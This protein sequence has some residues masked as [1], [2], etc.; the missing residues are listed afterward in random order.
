MGKN[1]AVILAGG[2]GSRSGLGSP[3]QFFKVAGKTVIEHTVNVFDNHRLIDEIAIV[4]HPLYNREIEEMVIR[5]KWKKVKKILAGGK[6]RYESSLA[7][8]DA[9]SSDPECCLI[10]HDA[11]RPLISN[12]I[13]DGIVKALE[14]YNAVDVAVPA[15]D[16]IIQ[17]DAKGEV[18]EKIPDRRFLRRVDHEFPI[19]ESTFLEY[20]REVLEHSVGDTSLLFIA[21]VIQ[22]TPTFLSIGNIQIVPYYVDI[23]EVLNEQTMKTISLKDGDTFRY[24]TT[25]SVFKLP[26]N[27]DFLT[28]SNYSHMALPELALDIEWNASP[29]L[30]SQSASIMKTVT[31][32]DEFYEQ[33]E[34][35]GYYEGENQTRQPHG[36]YCN[37]P[38]D[39]T[40]SSFTLQRFC[41]S[42][43]GPDI[44]VHWNSPASWSDV[45]TRSFRTHLGFLILVDGIEVS[46]YDVAAFINRISHWP[47]ETNRADDFSDL[48]FTL[49][50]LGLKYKELQ[51][52]H[53][54]SIVPYYVYYTRV[55]R[56][57]PVYLS[58]EPVIDA[59]WLDYSSEIIEKLDWLTITIDLDET[60]FN[61]GL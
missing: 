45:E 34:K 20:F 41:L 58:E 18:I 53:Q 40:G 19:D 33:N 5:N 8:I 7:A 55:N 24:T 28:L 27:Q 52:K 11:V 13:I 30:S 51:E 29:A 37:K 60:I 57:N 16:T 12:E 36:S 14:T 22:I 15:T 4:T 26:S 2:V 56:K 17:V 9:Y 10:F 1:I 32:W 3:K 35:E 47:D 43:S 59:G 50:P 44:E 46:R 61:A 21:E 39:F 31:V 38:L 25:G 48:Y 49:Y 23:S 54:I 6:E 42:P